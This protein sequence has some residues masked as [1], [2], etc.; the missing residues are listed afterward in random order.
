MCTAIAKEF[1]LAD[2]DAIHDFK[3]RKGFALTALK[4]YRRNDD[5]KALED[6]CANPAN[7]YLSPPIPALDGIRIILME[8]SGTVAAAKIADPEQFVNYN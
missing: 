5:R 1:L 2:I 6:S 4:K 3:R 7:K 8:I